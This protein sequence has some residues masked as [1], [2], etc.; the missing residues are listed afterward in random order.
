MILERPF[1]STILL[2]LIS[3]HFRKLE[4]IEGKNSCAP[5]KSLHMTGRE[6]KE[7]AYTWKDEEL[8][9]V[10]AGGFQDVIANTKSMINNGTVE[11]REEI[12]R[13]I[14]KTTRHSRPH[15]PPW[16]MQMA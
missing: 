5:G 6:W 4:D 3:Q 16:P 7:F 13:E 8:E 2:Y 1:S 12:V 14:E 9:P 15:V 10:M 11:H